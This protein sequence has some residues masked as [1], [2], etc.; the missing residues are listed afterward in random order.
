M[1]V[2]EASS[3]LIIS[4]GVKRGGSKIFFWLEFSSCLLTPMTTNRPAIANIAYN[5]MGELGSGGVVVGAAALAMWC[6]L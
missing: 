1:L 4:K 6:D 5:R 3:L 2:G